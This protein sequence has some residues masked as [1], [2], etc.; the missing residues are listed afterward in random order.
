MVEKIIPSVVAISSLDT[1]H[2]A[3]FNIEN[4]PE[5]SD[6]EMSSNASGVIIGDNGKEIWILTN[7][8]VISDA[9]SVLVTFHDNTNIT[10][11]VKGSFEDN[12][13]AII[14]VKMSDISQET[15]E[16]LTRIS[17]GNS[18]NIKMGQGII[19]VGNALGYG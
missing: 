7:A 17:I 8:H 12:D 16:S 15:I 13:I 2:P 19:A 11:Y 14:S 10:A 4:Q 18:D 6:D 9:K 5:I 3:G 1:P